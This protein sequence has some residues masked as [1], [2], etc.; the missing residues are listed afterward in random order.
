MK[1]GLFSI[2]AFVIC[3]VLLVLSVQ[4]YLDARRH[5]LM[6]ELADR[7][8][9]VT[10]GQIAQTGNTRENAVTRA[11]EEYSPAVI[12]IHVTRIEEYSSNPFFNDPFF[13]R[14][15]PN[16]I[17]KKRIQ[18]LGSGVIISEDGYIV[19]NAH[20]LGDNAVEIYVTLSGG[21]RC[22]AELIGTDPL[23]D[24][25]LLKI[26]R[27]ELP[28]I[29]MGDSD[30]IIIGEWVVALGNPFGL[31]NVSN[32]PI[33]TVGII[34]SMNMNFGETRDGHV[35]QDMIQ[36]DASIN[37]GNSGGALVNMDGEL[38]GINTFIFTGNDYNASGSIGIGFAI[39][40]NR[41]TPNKTS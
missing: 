25:A 19:T 39:P 17:Y 28:Y 4:F 38:I 36:T 37:S 9:A 11:I 40:I 35:Y 24:I 14:F 41:A 20:V 22:R 2:I 13:S 7:D 15:F 29:E 3:L 30:A 34:S 33:A 27:K 10:T 12:G 16:N 32:K 23:T 8:A 21:K 6:R 5:L 1:K 18:S 26:D 31:F